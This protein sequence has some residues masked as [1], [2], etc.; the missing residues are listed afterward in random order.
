MKWQSIILSLVCRDFSAVSFPPKKEYGLQ[1]APQDLLVS[2]SHLER[3]R[4][5]IPKK[6]GPS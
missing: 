2:P 3:I 4:I 6:S 5:D 1:L